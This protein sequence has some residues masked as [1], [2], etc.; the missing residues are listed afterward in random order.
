MVIEFVACKSLVG[1]DTCNHNHHDSPYNSNLVTNEKTK[2]RLVGH[3]K[4]SCFLVTW[5][6]PQKNL[7]YVAEVETMIDSMKE[8]FK[9]ILQIQGI[10]DISHATI[11][12]SKTVLGLTVRRGSISCNGLNTNI[13]SDT[14]FNYQGFLVSLSQNLI[15]QKESWNSIT[16]CHSFVIQLHF[17]NC[18]PECVESS[19]LVLIFR[20]SIQ[21]HRIDHKETVLVAGSRVLAL[22]FYWCQWMEQQQCLAFLSLQ[23]FPEP[24]K[25]LFS[26]TSK[27][28]QQQYGLTCVQFFA[29]HH[30]STAFSIPANKFLFD[31]P[32][33]VKQDETLSINKITYQGL[34]LHLVLWNEGSA[35]ICY[36][37]ENADENLNIESN[38]KRN[39]NSP[40]YIITSL[41]HGCH[42]TGQLP[43]RFGTIVF[44]PHDEHQL[45]VMS[46][47]GPTHIVDLDPCHKP[48]Y[49]IVSSDSAWPFNEK[50]NFSVVSL[51]N[52][53]YS[54]IIQAEEFLPFMLG[55]RK[56]DLLSLFCFTRSLHNRISIVHYLSTHLKLEKRNFYMQKI[57]KR[58]GCDPWHPH[59]EKIFEEFLKSSSFSRLKRDNINFHCLMYHIPLLDQEK[60]NQK[61][62]DFYDQ[63]L[64]VDLCFEYSKNLHNLPTDSLLL[65]SGSDAGNFWH[66][67][68][69]HLIALNNRQNDTSAFCVKSLRRDMENLD[70]SIEKIDLLP[71]PVTPDA[72]T[73]KKHQISHTS[74][75][76]FCG[77][78]KPAQIFGN[79][80]CPSIINIPTLVSLPFEVVVDDLDR[81]EKQVRVM[82]RFLNEHLQISCPLVANSVIAKLCSDY[83]TA[84]VQQSQF[85][86]HAIFNITEKYRDQSKPGATLLCNIPHVDLLQCLLENYYMACKQLSFPVPSGFKS[87]FCEV[88]FHSMHFDLFVQHVQSGI[89]ILQIESVKKIIKALDDSTNSMEKKLFCIGYLPKEEG[90]TILKKWKNSV[91]AKYKA[92]RNARDLLSQRDAR[93]PDILKVTEQDVEF[94]SLNSSETD[95]TTDAIEVKTPD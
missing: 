28:K 40:S 25:S 44:A 26:S 3:V 78:H 46:E 8:F 58:I 91:G 81:T 42:I 11:N 36:Q 54:M 1:L 18:S 87:A 15:S 48:G 38:S 21:V 50:R 92:C 20:H 47:N 30:H 64:P 63:A 59:V 2:A 24:R 27:D 41:N 94:L 70:Y 39:N 29:N 13:S 89:L 4:A 80:T 75:C 93:S 45:I 37:K 74:L 76:S 60:T 56:E 55:I 79:I 10:V 69:H 66:V 51:A 83:I 34:N 7:T 19:L 62:H 49:Y 57:L 43:S 95:F 85:L 90:E 5:I 72:K 61:S 33:I 31:E 17:L 53:G 68:W 6:D 12:S 32:L 71:T 73:P 22:D 14:G 35:Y 23:S 52:Q 88:S 65:A 77:D 16:D 82:W 84:Q 9:I 67:L 86:C